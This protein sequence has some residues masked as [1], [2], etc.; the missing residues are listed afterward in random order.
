MKKQS[1]LT[2]CYL[3]R[4]EFWKDPNG[5]IRQCFP[6]VAGFQVDYPES[7]NLTLVRT[8]HACPICLVQKEDF[9]CI[10]K[11]SEARTVEQM[12]SIYQKSQVMAQQTDRAGAESLLKKNGL[13]NAQ[14]QFRLIHYSDSDHRLSDALILEPLP[15]GTYRTFFGIYNTPIYTLRYPQIS[16][17][18]SGR[19]Y[20]LTL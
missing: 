20:G 2:F 16:F 6:V 13:V 14:V 3:Y 9:G 15:P 1:Y 7:C 5:N 11:Y 4:G 19:E 12:R 17:I 8:N 18:R 10:F